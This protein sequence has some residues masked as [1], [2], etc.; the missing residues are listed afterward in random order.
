[1]QTI[2]V[3]RPK[4]IEHKGFIIIFIDLVGLFE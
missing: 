2:A 4:V 3:K 1:M